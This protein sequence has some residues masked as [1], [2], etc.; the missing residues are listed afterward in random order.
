MIKSKAKICFILA[1]ELSVKAFLLNHLKVLSQYYDITIIT[2]TKNPYFLTEIGIPICV[3]QMN[4][5]R[6]INIMSDF[7]SLLSLVKILYSG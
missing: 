3:L 2:N 5:T 4:I 7:K 1:T 6:N